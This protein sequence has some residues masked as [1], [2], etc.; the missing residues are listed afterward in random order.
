MH[1][2]SSRL[3]IILRTNHNYH[4]L[5]L[6]RNSSG[7]NDAATEH[8]YVNINMFLSFWIFQYQTI[9]TKLCFVQ[10]F[11]QKIKYNAIFEQFWEKWKL[12]QQNLNKDLHSYLQFNGC[13]LQQ[14]NLSSWIPSLINFRLEIVFGHK[15]WIFKV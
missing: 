15:S 1:I 9:Y 8:Q 10:A 13:H 7:K 12:L 4:T 3:Q 14:Y 6:Q 5:T 11:M 2:Q